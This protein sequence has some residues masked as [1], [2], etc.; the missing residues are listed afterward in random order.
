MGLSA[1]CCLLLISVLSLNS[2]CGVVTVKGNRWERVEVFLISTHRIRE[3]SDS[4]GCNTFMGA[5]R[6]LGR[7]GGEAPDY[8]EWDGWTVYDDKRN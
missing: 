5:N 8:E 6:E 2:A 7:F 1:L 3:G 4:S